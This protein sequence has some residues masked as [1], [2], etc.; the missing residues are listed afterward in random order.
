MKQVPK[1]CALFRCLRRGGPDHLVGRIS[2]LP[3]PAVSV[4]AVDDIIIVGRKDIAVRQDTDVA[5]K[6]GQVIGLD[7][8]FL[9][10]LSKSLS[11]KTPDYGAA[12]AINTVD[13]V[14]TGSEIEPPLIIQQ[15]R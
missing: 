6:P 1:R 15:S 11:S 8:E 13:M 9:F 2:F 5:L 14:V 7:P 10:H 4:Q 3:L 12:V